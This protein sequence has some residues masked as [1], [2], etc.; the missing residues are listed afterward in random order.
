MDWTRVEIDKMLDLSDSD[1]ITLMNDVVE[2]VKP[3]MG[4]PTPNATKAIA[5]YNQKKAAGQELTG[6]EK[7]IITRWCAKSKDL[8]ASLRLQKLIEEPNDSSKP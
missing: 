2:A 5:K 1:L 8:D 4:E 6:P 3:T 7:F